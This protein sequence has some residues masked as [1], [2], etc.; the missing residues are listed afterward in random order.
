MVRAANLW[1]I[2]RKN[3]RCMVRDFATL[4][5]SIA[6]FILVLSSMADATTTTIDPLP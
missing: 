2:A 1:R 4:L 5:V 3:L 6:T